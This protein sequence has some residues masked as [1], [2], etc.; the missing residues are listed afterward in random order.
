MPLPSRGLMP[1]MGGKPRSARRSRDGGAWSE[2]PEY[3]LASTAPDKLGFIVLRHVNSARTNGYWIE[4][5]RRIRRHYPTNKILVIDDDSDREHLKETQFD[6]VR[7]IES[8]YRAA[9]SCFRITTIF[10]IGNSIGR[11]S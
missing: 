11:S 1:S 5:C 9:P 6:N 7:V 4:C 8:E 10:T 3:P 2:I